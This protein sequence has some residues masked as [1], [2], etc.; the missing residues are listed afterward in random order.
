MKKTDLK[1]SSDSIYEKA[2]LEYLIERRELELEAVKN[3]LDGER[4]INSL[5]AAFMMY[6]L[7][8]SGKGDES[9]ITA[10]V[11]KQ[12]LNALVGKYFAACEDNGDTYRAVFTARDAAP[13]ADS[14]R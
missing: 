10:E 11:N 7:I 13:G 6:L 4:E 2:R 5:C 12:E 3:E 14:G 1:R 9:I 8:K